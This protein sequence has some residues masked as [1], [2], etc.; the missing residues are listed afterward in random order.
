MGFDT[1]A[2]NDSFGCAHG[3]IPSPWV[4]RIGGDKLAPQRRQWR[5]AQTHGAVLKIGATVKFYEENYDENAC[6]NL[7]R[8]RSYLATTVTQCKGGGS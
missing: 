3:E 4:E 8:D 1:N 5:A 7:Q 2:L 6:S